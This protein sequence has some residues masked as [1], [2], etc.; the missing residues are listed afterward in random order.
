MWRIRLARELPRYLVCALALAGLAASARFAIAPPNASVARIEQPVADPRDRAAEGY[1]T[2]FAR[3]YLSWSAAEASHPGGAS[4]E[5][6]FDAGAEAGLGLP[7]S[8]AQQVQWAEVVQARESQPGVHVYTVAAQTD[9]AGLTYLAVSVG[10]TSG[11]SLRLAGY[12]A[13][14]GPPATVPSSGEP[15]LR[16]VTDAALTTVL[17]RGLRNYLSASSSE[18]AADLVARAR[19][20]PPRLSL[21]LDSI[22]RIDWAADGTS[23][24]AVVQAHDGRG[25]Q[26]TLAYEVDVVRQQG[27]WEIAAIEM[28]P[29]A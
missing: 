12:P 26:Y 5:S 24:L 9:T 1:A 6:F 21:S 15:R 17:A 27:R 2:L 29:N 13:F 28:D 19:V 14:V 11:G 3:R 4:L 23:V 18:L 10:R 20:S 7:P 8:G 22:Q 16:E 25:V